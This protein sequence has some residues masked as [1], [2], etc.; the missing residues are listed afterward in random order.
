ML[1]YLSESGIS[2]LECVPYD[3]YFAGKFV[4][5]GCPSKCQSDAVEFSQWKSSVRE[6]K[7]VNDLK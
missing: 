3:S 2:T 7:T 6:V 1:R 5:T 4:P